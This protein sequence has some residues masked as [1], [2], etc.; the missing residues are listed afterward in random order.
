MLYK[1]NVTYR[2]INSKWST[3]YVWVFLGTCSKRCQKMVC[4]SKSN[5][6]ERNKTVLEIGSSGTWNQEM[7]FSRIV[8]RKSDSESSTDAMD[9]IPPLEDDDSS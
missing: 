5:V 3:N 4:K 2:L 6:K 1:G 9:E 8:K 7:D